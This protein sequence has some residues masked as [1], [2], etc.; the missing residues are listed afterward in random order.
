MAIIVLSMTYYRN[1]E[2]EISPQIPY[3][4][5]HANLQVDGNSATSEGG[6]I[7]S[8]GSLTIDSSRVSNNSAG[9]GGGISGYGTIT[10]S[11]SQVLSMGCNNI[12]H[13]K[14]PDNRKIPL[15]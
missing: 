2:V 4:H 8:A 9:D 5:S 11:A 7:F 6:G 3:K 12:V 15:Q 13:H 1:E 10:L 14:C